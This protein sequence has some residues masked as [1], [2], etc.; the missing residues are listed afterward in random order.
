M[1]KFGFG[2][3][4]TEIIEAIYQYSQD[5]SVELMLIA[6]KNQIDYDGGYV[7]N[8]NTQQYVEHLNVLKK[9][10]PQSKIMI[11]RDHCGPGFKRDDCDSLIDTYQTVA[12][13]INAGF[14]LLHIDFCHYTGNIIQETIKA[15]EF[16][17]KLNEDIEFEIGTDSIEDEILTKQQVLDNIKQFIE[18]DPL[19]YVINTGSLIKENKQIGT[20]HSD[21]LQDIH[22]ELQD[23]GWADTKEHNSDYLSTE[24][25][26][27]RNG[28]VDAMNIA[29]QLGVV[30]TTTVLAECQKYGI[31]V[32]DFVNLVYHSNRWVK[33]D[34]GN[35]NGNPYL[36]TIV[37][38][39]YHYSSKEYKR[40][41]RQLRSIAI[42]NKIIHNIK[43]V[44]NHYVNTY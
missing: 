40:L 12:E 2:P 21:L 43:D 35:L 16:A 24:Q 26:K 33:W 14:D 17:R 3:M 31:N 28:C 6:S 5:H 20:F 41:I 29:P 42:E 22:Y 25:I 27:L 13:D 19:Y 8:W 34:N 9:Q 7:N 36:S 18:F 32:D 4:S 44:I 23:L 37:A 1:V 38:G 11:C 15:L 39:H 30:Q 10:Y